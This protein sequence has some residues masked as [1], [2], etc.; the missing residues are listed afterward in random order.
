MARIVLISWVPIRKQYW[1]YAG[2]C[3]V[4]V[5]QVPE[6]EEENSSW[7]AARGTGQRIKRTFGQD[8]R[9]L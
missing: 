8:T 1:A 6:A 3:P 5:I 9:A 4:Q 2:Y 7:E